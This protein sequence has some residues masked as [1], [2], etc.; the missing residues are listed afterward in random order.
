MKQLNNLSPSQRKFANKIGAERLSKGGKIGQAMADG[1]KLS[2]AQISNLH[3]QHSRE[4]GMFKNMSN[5][6]RAYYKKILN[7]MTHDHQGFVTKTMVG[8]E[9]ATTQFRLSWMKASNAVKGM[10]STVSAAASKVGMFLSGVMGYLAIFGMLLMAGK[11]LMSWWNKDANKILE[12][13][14]ERADASKESIKGLNEELM[15]MSQ[16]RAQGLIASG[17]QSLLHTF[18]AVQSVDLQRVAK[19]LT[20]LGN[21]SGVNQEKFNELEEEFM[22][23]IRTLG[24]LDSRFIKI[25]FVPEDKILHRANF[26]YWAKDKS[27]IASFLN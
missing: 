3:S 14:N 23:T 7:Q 6:K 5:K 1:K 24:E 20:Y 8:T 21:I 2:K 10:L 27:R 17:Q 19:D 18:E 12:N 22:T 15:K 25:G 13:F 11:A 4:V 26:I 9:K 16:V